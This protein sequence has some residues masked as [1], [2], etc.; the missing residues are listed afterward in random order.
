MCAF[1]GVSTLKVKLYAVVLDYRIQVS[2]NKE[3]AY[4]LIRNK[5][6]R[7]MPMSHKL[8]YAMSVLTTVPGGEANVYPFVF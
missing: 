3:T 8:I 6:I 7:K 5:V 2:L 4:R 1:I